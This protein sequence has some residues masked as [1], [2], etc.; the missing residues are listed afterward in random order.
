VLLVWPAKGELSLHELQSPA[1]PDPG[2]TTPAAAKATRPEGATEVSDHMARVQIRMVD[3]TLL[4]VGGDASDATPWSKG[5]QLDVAK[6]RTHFAAALAPRA[7]RELVDPLLIDAGLNVP[8]QQVLT[9]W[10]TARAAGYRSVLFHGDETRQE[11]DPA[12]RR[13]I[14]GLAKRFAWPVRTVGERVQLQVPDGE[15]LILLDGPRSYREMDALMRAAVRAHIWR[16]GFVGQKDTE[17]FVK[18]PTNF[19][20]DS[21]M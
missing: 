19:S 9:L 8:A 3:T 16:V 18:L 11:I 12:M 21:G 1:P 6:L 13:Q 15:L 10:E 20:F 14:D 4:V 17:T 2:A 7:G 5:P